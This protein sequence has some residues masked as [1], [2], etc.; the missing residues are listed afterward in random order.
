MAVK[1]P[2]NFIIYVE[3]DGRLT[4]DFLKLL[5]L[6]AAMLEDHEARITALEP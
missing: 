1:R 2:S 4:V 3:K 5:Q 6:W